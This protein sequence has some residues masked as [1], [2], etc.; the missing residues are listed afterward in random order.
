M[1][2]VICEFNL[3]KT[4]KYGDKCQ[5]YHSDLAYL[6]QYLEKD[7]A[8]HWHNFPNELNKKI[9]KAYCDPKIKKFNLK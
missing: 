6:W 7:D 5:Y 8:T 2:P 4:C 9:E 1:K 3:K